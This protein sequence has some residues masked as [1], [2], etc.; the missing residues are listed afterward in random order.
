MKF[1]GLYKNLLR[2]RELN[3]KNVLAW[4]F[5][6]IFQACVIMFGT[7][8]LLKIYFYILLHLLL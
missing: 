7:M 3:L 4:S 5:K 2:G 8:F 1:P 6:S